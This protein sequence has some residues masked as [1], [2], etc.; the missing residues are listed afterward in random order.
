MSRIQEE[1]EEKAT[2]VATGGYADLIA[3]ETKIIN[4]VNPDLTLM[5][6]KILFDMNK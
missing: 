1:L 4:V 6:L 3:D 2:V 5:G